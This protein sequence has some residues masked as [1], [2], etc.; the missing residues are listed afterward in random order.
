MTKK[1][2][3]AAEKRVEKAYYR[4]CSGVQINMMDIPRVF[5]VG[6]LAV[7]DGVDDEELGQALRA[8]VDT[9]AYKNT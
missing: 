1:E 5:Q 8:F 7:M 3:K 4:T 2:K 9:I 6:M